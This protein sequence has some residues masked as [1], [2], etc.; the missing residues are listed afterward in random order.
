[1]IIKAVYENNVLKPLEKLVLK[2]GEEVEIEVKKSPI[3][4]LESVIK[5]SKRGWVDELIENPDLEPI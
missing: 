4:R 5:I 1:M 2:E 3:D